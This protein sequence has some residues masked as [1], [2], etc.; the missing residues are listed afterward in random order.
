MVSVVQFQSEWSIGKQ[1][2]QARAYIPEGRS[3]FQQEHLGHA[4]NTQ[5]SLAFLKKSLGNP[6][7][8][9]CVSDPDVA[10]W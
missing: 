1:P 7:L 6:R 2:H 9:S 8:L 4:A 10:A 3:G 5:L